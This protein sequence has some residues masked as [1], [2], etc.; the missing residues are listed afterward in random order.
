MVSHKLM[1]VYMG[2]LIHGFCLFKLF[3]IGPK[4]LIIF[5][6]GYT[7]NILRQSLWAVAYLQM[8]VW[9]PDRLVRVKVQGRAGCIEFTVFL[10]LYVHNRLMS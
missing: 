9:L 1:G 4:E 7:Y 3:P 8:T 2:V 6:T 10:Y 5:S